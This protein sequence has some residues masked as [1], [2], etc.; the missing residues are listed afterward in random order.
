MHERT[1]RPERENPP[2]ERLFNVDL[3]SD[4]QVL[5]LFHGIYE[6]WAKSDGL[7]S[8]TADPLFYQLA[9]S[10][11]DLASRDPE[12]AK[13]LV[14]RCEQSNEDI[15]HR[16]VGYT[17]Q[18]L[19]DYDY[20]FTRDAL[21]SVYVGDAQQR[22]GSENA[23]DVAGHQMGILMRDRLTPEQ[24]ADFNARIAAYEP[25]DEWLQLEPSPPNETD[26]F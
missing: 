11:R 15:D 22:S 9:L 17:A 20:A 21:I 10:V 24:A 25:D 3:M 12:R 5:T 13:N 18:A 4:D 16:I 6:G 14:Q 8:E 2:F 19:I 26:Y 23:Q 7:I 1:P